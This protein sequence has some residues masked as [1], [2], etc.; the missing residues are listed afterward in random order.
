MYDANCRIFTRCG[1]PYEIVDA[2]AGP[3]GGNASHELISPSPTGEDTI[4]N[5]NNG[6]YASNVEKCAIGERTFDL[7]GAATGDLEE[8]STPGCPGIEDVVDF[9]KRQLKT[10]L[11]TANMLKSLLFVV[12]KRSDIDRKQPWYVLAVVRGDHDGN[13][14]KIR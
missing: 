3:I 1:I 8:V 7:V 13:E 9:F 5:S 4:H 12:T 14:A 11:K 10:K 6:N 2:E